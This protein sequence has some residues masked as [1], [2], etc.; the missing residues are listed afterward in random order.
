[1]ARGDGSMDR[2]GPTISYS[3]KHF[4][5][6]ICGYLKY[7]FSETWQTWSMIAV[8]FLVVIGMMTLF[9]QFYGNPKEKF[10]KTLNNSIMY[11]VSII[12]NQGIKKL[13][14]KFSFKYKHF[15]FIDFSCLKGHFLATGISRFSLRILL[16]IWLLMMVVLIN[17]YTGTLTSHM[18][19]PKL[20]PIPQSLE[21]L[22]IRTNEYQITIMQNYLLA[23]SFLVITDWYIIFHCINCIYIFK[24]RMQLRGHTKFQEILYVSILI[25]FSKNNL[26]PQ[27]LF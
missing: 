23:D 2:S 22:A 17:A 9:I 16:G 24:Y 12:A 8:T 6:I 1:M 26:K 5:S 4:L 19:A 13:K 27:V 11:V 10:L 7:Y 18:T 14:I 3:C 15:A 25:W 21:E 20:K